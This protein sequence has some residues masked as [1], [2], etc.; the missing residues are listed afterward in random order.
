MRTNNALV[1]ATMMAF[2]T[3]GFA[4]TTTNTGA[5]P[6]ASVNQAERPAEGRAATRDQMITGS[7]NGTGNALDGP[8]H[9]PDATRNNGQ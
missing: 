1:L 9:A 5:A 7:P 6:G 3:P 2:A 8:N 4:Q